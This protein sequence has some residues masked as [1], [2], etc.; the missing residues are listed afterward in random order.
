M[1]RNRCFFSTIVYTKLLII[2]ESRIIII[3]NALVLDS[4]FEYTVLLAHHDLVPQDKLMRL[5]RLSL[6]FLSYF[7]SCE[8]NHNIGVNATSVVIPVF[9]QICGRLNSILIP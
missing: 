5:L 6:A 8:R 1:E 7:I 4:T 3:Q 9:A 2:Q